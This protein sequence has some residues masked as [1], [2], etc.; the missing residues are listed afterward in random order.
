M[1]P[2]AMRKLMAHFFGKSFET[3]ESTNT[4]AWFWKRNY[5]ET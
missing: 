5:G 2:H 3:P 1:P 4:I